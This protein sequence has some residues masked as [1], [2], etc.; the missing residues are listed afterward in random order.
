[1]S[2]KIN[3]YQMNRILFFLIL[4]LLCLCGCNNS[5]HEWKTI[6]VGNY[7]FDVPSDFKLIEYESIDS[8]AGRIEGDSMG[9]D[10]DYGYYSNS[11]VQTR[12]EYW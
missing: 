2:E 1:M 5:T 3:I 7:I 8:Y 11:L 4:L 9:L 10:F 12:Q 6:E